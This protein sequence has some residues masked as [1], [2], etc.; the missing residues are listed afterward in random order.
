[1]IERARLLAEVEDPGGVKR[2]KLKFTV[3]R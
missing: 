1:M 2:A 3:T